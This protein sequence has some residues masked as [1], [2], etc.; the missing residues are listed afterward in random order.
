MKVPAMDHLRLNS[1]RV[2]KNAVLT[3]K[4]T[5]SPLRPFYLGSPPPLGMST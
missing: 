3:L 4:Y 2:A 1:V 5:T